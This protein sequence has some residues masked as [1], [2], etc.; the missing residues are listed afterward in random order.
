MQQKLQKVGYVT[1]TAKRDTLLGDTDTVL[2]GHEFH[3]S[4]MEP[5]VE[6]FPWAFHLEGGRKPQSYDGGY[7]TDNV[8]ASYL[9]LNFAGSDAGAQHFVDICANYKAKRS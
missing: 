8:L 3:F 7:A 4:T 5:T 6:N 9:H 2:R 1:A